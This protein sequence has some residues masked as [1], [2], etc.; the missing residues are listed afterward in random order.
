M[1]QGGKVVAVVL[2]MMAYIAP[3]P[4]Q[5]TSAQGHII[6]SRVIIAIIAITGIVIAVIKGIRMAIAP[7]VA[8]FHL[9][10]GPLR[11]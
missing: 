11:I 1:T 6:S 7:L 3:V 8:K 9:P 4:V 5:V 10:E 2:Q